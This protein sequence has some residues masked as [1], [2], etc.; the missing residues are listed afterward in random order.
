[1]SDDDYALISRRRDYGKDEIVS[2]VIRR[3]KELRIE[4]GKANSE[5]DHLNAE[6]RRLN[7]NKGLHDELSR[8]ARIQIRKE[9]IYDSH[10]REMAALREKVK[11]LTKDN[12]ELITK[13][14]KK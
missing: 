10:K 1:M 7:R 11:R 4:L 13:L 6:I 14:Y 9:E 5:I 3:I 8:E 12:H 2:Y